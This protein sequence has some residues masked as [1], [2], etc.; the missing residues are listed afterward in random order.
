MGTPERVRCTRCGMTFRVDGLPAA[1][2]ECDKC[3]DCY[4]IM[5][6]YKPANEAFAITG[7]TGESREFTEPVAA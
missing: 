7:I 2:V 4:R 3:P 5:W 6:H 1:Q